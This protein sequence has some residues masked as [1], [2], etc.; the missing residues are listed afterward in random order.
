MGKNLHCDGVVRIDCGYPAQVRY[1]WHWNRT[2][3]GDRRG[4]PTGQVLGLQSCHKIDHAMVGPKGKRRDNVP[5]YLRPHG[6]K[7]YLGFL[8]DSLI[9]RPH[10]DI[11]IELRQ[12]CRDGRITRR[13]RDFVEIPV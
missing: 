6:E 11:V 7:D 12:L 13:K 9:V 8:K 5:G 2:T 4:D 10:S 3:D 1:E